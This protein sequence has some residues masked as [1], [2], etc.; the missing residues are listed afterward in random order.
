MAILR[1]FISHKMNEVMAASDTVGVL[2]G[3]KLVAVRRTAETDR[4]E[5]AELG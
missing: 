2:R 3:G 4:S 5:L 1:I